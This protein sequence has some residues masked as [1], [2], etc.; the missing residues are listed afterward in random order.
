MKKTLLNL[1]F[2]LFCLVGYNQTIIIDSYKF[3]DAC[4]VGFFED[5]AVTDGDCEVNGTA[6]FTDNS[7][8]DISISS[9]SET[10]GTS[11]FSIRLTM[12][13]STGASEIVSLALTGLDPAATYNIVARAKR[14]GTGTN[15][16]MRIEAADGWDASDTSGIVNT[17]TFADY[18]ITGSPSGTT[19]TIELF[20]TTFNT[21]GNTSEWAYITITEI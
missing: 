17:S 19:A 11:S 18:T 8:G 4:G 3:G 7:G 12:N 13:A 21:S 2:L 6:G 20:T 1:F 16:R 14:T 5:N 15:W 10:E 9:I